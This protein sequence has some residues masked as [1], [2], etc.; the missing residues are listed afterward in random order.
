MVELSQQLQQVPGVRLQNSEGLSKP[1]IRG[2]SGNRILIFSDN[3]RYDNFQFGAKHAMDLSMDGVENI[4]IIKGPASLL[5]GSDALGGIIYLVP[6]KFSPKNRYSGEIKTS[7]GSN[8]FFKAGLAWKQSFEKFKYLIRF[9]QTQAGD[10]TI[11]GNKFVRNSKHQNRDFKIGS[12]YDFKNHKTDLRFHISESKIGLYKGIMTEPAKQFEEPFQK[13]GYYSVSL[14]D[15]IK[16][17]NGDIRIKAGL[18]EYDRALIKSGSSFIGMKL[19]SYQLNA[20]WKIDLNRSTLISGVDGLNKEVKNYGQHYLLPNSSVQNIAVFTT[21][22]WEWIGDLTFQSGIRWDGIGIQTFADNEHPYSLNKFLQN[23]NGS[24]GVKKDFEEK[25]FLRF[26]LSKGFRTPNLSE[27]T[28]HGLHAGRIEVGNP[29]LKSEENFQT[30]FSFEWKSIH[31]EFFYNAFYNRIFNYIFLSP[32]GTFQNN[33]PVYAYKQQNATLYGMETGFHFHPHP[34]DF[35]H[36]KLQ[37]ETVTGRNDQNQFLPL[38]PVDRILG[39]LEIFN[40]FKS[41]NPEWNT[42]MEWNYHFPAKRLA[43]NENF[44]TGYHLIHFYTNISFH[45]EKQDWTFFLR[46]NNLL[47]TSYIPHLSAYRDQNIPD[48]GRRIWLGMNIL[49]K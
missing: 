16:T 25:A 12:G 34:L 41:K 8:D 14:S 46:V 36:L 31:L 10:Y 24:F 30:D 23:L 19:K 3:L 5:Y 42:G 47:N 35:L 29:A 4:E 33:Y 22:M 43:P 11:P 18:S 38:M 7:L 49:F 26:N 48:P 21:H 39:K 13:L 27:L 37:Y 20:K 9:T 6:E 17:S 28:S 32:A 40:P 45:R 2:L 1:V 15:V 44:R